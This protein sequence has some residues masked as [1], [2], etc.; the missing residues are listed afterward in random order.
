MRLSRCHLYLLV[1]LMIAIV[2]PAVFSQPGPGMGGR[3][4]KGKGGRGGGGGGFGDPSAFWDQIAPGKDSIDV[5][6]IEFPPQMQG[7]STFIRQRYS[8]F[9]QTKGVT[10]GIMTRAMFDEMNEGFRQRMAQGGF[11]GGFGGPG[12]GFGGKGKGGLE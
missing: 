8:D 7:F 1:A 9:L 5:N 3:G 6:N 12:G 10:D 4:G 11:G 2:G